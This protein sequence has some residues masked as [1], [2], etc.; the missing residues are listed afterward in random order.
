[1]GLYWQESEWASGWY[2]AEA[3]IKGERMTK[4]AQH[5]GR[6]AG[7][8]DHP[9][10]LRSFEEAKSAYEE[11]CKTARIPAYATYNED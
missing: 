3:K 7:T 10:A 8:P 2:K 11:A 1:M 9:E 4:A 5:A 6:L